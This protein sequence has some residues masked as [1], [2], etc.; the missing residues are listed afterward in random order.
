LTALEVGVSSV[1]ISLAVDASPAKGSF[2]GNG[3]SLT[4]AV[5]STF[6]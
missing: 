3:S 5:L 1:T 2:N 6:F 4:V